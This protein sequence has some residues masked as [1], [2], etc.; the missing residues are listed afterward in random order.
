MIA[1]PFISFLQHDRQA[2]SVRI[3]LATLADVP[4]AI[5]ISSGPMIFC[6]TFSKQPRFPSSSLCRNHQVWA[7]CERTARDRRR[8]PA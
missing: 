6:K 4:S 2:G 5:L 1:H 8:D 7:P 3:S